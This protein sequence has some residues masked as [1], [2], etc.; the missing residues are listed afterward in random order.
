MLVVILE[1]KR[2]AGNFPDVYVKKKENATLIFP[3]GHCVYK[4]HS[5]NPV[6]FF[7][8]FIIWVFSFISS[9]MILFS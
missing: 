1:R 9:L 2:S 6:L 8:L 4:T 3:F 7:V 5:D